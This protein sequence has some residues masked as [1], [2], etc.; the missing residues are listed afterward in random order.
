M[1]VYAVSTGLRVCG[2]GEKNA[3][4]RLSNVERRTTNEN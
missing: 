3:D 1:W 2:E 4:C